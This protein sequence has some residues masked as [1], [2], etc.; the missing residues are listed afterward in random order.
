MIYLYGLVEANPDMLRSSLNGV[1]GLQG[2]LDVS[3]LEGWSLVHSEQDDAEILPKRRLMLTHTRA[4]EQMLNCGAVLP[5]RFGL[6]AR[7]VA[8]TAELVA[9]Q[10]PRIAAEFDRI[11]GA[12]ELG[13]RVSFPRQTA[14][15]ATLAQ[16]PE[17]AQQRDA[18]AHRG[19]EARY[20][21]AEFGGRLAEAIDRRRGAA[22]STLVAALSPRVRDHV[23][24]APDADCE[25]LRA[26]F[27]V[28]MDTQAE[29]EAHVEDAVSRLDFAPGAEPLIQIV[30]PVPVYN[31]VQLNL[32]LA[33]E[34][35]AA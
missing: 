17:L 35:V 24:R 20:A 13:L 31:F 4:L 16:F 3:A 10:I 19:A 27:L 25:V 28:D 32:S 14:L 26:E 2:P 6:V 1:P 34:E 12:V 33:T 8:E 9:A 21:I 30:G 11:R 29:F 5:A 18:L 22:Q 7:D 23:L 15:E